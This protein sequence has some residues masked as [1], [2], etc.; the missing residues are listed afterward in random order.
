M[1]VEYVCI[2]VRSDLAF[3]PLDQLSHD[4]LEATWIELLLPKSK[5]IVCGVV[6]RP[7]KQTDFYELVESVCLE[8]SYFNE[9]ECVLLGE[10]YRAIKD[11]IS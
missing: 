10:M 7:P 8:T 5:R 11:P 9:T 6:Y 3:N 2:Y 1:A 4:N